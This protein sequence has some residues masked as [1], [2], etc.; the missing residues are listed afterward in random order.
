MPASRWTSAD[1]G[2]LH[3]QTVIITGASSGLGLETARQLGAAGAR[4][5]LAVRNPDKAR[6][7]ADAM[8]GDTDVRRLDV[9]D[10]SSVQDFA[11]AWEGPIDVL[12]NNAGIMAGPE[13]RSVDGFELQFATNHLGPF[14]L[15]SLLMGHITRRVVTVASQLH[16]RAKLDLNDLNWT[17]HRYNPQVA[18]ANSKLANLLFTAELAR[19][20]GDAHSPVLAVAAHPGIAKT[21]LA[22]AGGGPAVMINR[23][24]GRVFNDVHR[25]ALPLQYAATQEIPA[26]AYVGP[27][28]LGHLRGYPVLHDGS[29]ESRDPQLARELWDASV[30]LTGAPALAG[31][32][33]SAAA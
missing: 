28:G 12:I 5:V 1:L 24:A 26:G 2:D 25:G 11:A 16:T 10:L 14:L 22:A 15:T 30:R 32:A 13:R 6:P 4:V 7:L 23:V 9:S 29:A 18:Y 8:A 3:G 19:R 27:G 31:S 33:G 17:E 20:L 21:N